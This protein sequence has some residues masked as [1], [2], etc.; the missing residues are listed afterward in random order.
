MN[1]RQECS[2]C[3]RCVW[4]PDVDCGIESFVEHN[5]LDGAKYQALYLQQAAKQHGIAL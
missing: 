2:D 4:Q 1:Q 5:A 3:E